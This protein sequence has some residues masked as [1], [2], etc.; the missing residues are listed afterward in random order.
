MRKLLTLAIISLLLISTFSIIQPQVKAETSTGLYAGGTNPGVVYEYKGGT[1]WASISSSLGWSITS[2]VNYKGKLFASVITHPDIYSSVGKVYRY[3]GAPDWTLVGT[4]DK[5]VTF[6]IIYKG[7]LYA[8]TATPAR[9]YKYIPAT[10]SWTKVLEYTPWFGFRSAY[11]WGDWL[12]LGEWYW[13]RFARWDGNTFQEFQPHY[14]GSCI[15]SIEEYKGALYAGAYIGRI[16]RVTAEPPVATAIWGPEPNYRYAWSLKTFKGYLYIGFDAN[17]TGIAPL[18]RYDGISFTQVWSYSTTTT[19]YHEGIISMATD[20]TYLYVGVGGQAVGY[21]PYMSG[22]GT[23]KV[24]RSSDGI[25]FEL[26]SETMGTGIQIL[27][28]PTIPDLILVSIEPIQVISNAKAL[29]ALKPTVI[30]INIK[31]TFSTRM[32]VDIFIFYDFRNRLYIERGPYGNGTPIDPGVNIVYIPGGPVYKE[33]HE[34]HPSWTTDPSWLEWSGS[35][36]DDKIEVWLDPLDKIPEIDEANNRMVRG[37]KIVFPRQLRILIIPVYFPDIGQGPFEPVLDFEREF[38][39]ATFPVSHK[40]TVPPTFEWVERHAIAWPGNP[41]YWDRSRGRWEWRIDWLY[42]NV[43]MPISRMAETAGWNRTVIVLQSLGDYDAWGLAPGMLGNPENR[44]PVIVTSRALEVLPGVV[45]HEIGHTFYLWHPHDIGPEIYDAYRYWVARRDFGRGP[46]PSMN[47]FM[48]YRSRVGLEVWI[49]KTRFDMDFANVAPGWY[50]AP[51]DPVAGVPPYRYRLEFA[52][53]RWNLMD[54]LTVN[55]HAVNAEPIILISGIMFRNGTIRL[56]PWYRLM[57]VPNIANGTVGNYSIVLISGGQIMAR[58]GFNASFCRLIE[59]DGILINVEWDKIPFILKIP[60]FPETTLIQIRDNA[61]N[62]LV[63]R[64]LTLNPPKV[65]IVYPNGGE[66]LGGLATHTI[67]W[68]AYDPDGDPLTY[69]I[70]YSEDN[71]ETWIPLA[72]DLNETNYLWDTSRLKTGTNYLI[73]VIATDGVN[74]GEDIS[75]NAFTI[76]AGYTH[77]IIDLD[78]DTLNL[79]SQGEWITIYIELPKGYNIRQIDIS[80]IK[81]NAT[82]SALT[83]PIG[84]G[85]YDADGVPDLMVKFDRN[86]VKRLFGVP[87]APKKYFIVIT[88]KV[89]NV[90]FVGTD[91]V[92]V[93]SPP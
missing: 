46:A 28:V 49:D 93:I 13:D 92:L 58:M 60:Y 68:E 88:G 33:S 71:G 10:T 52:T 2:L 66:I 17:G 44:I 27:Y 76:L 6:L 45:A 1:T 79:K 22:V 5:Q 4:L 72:I 65:N 89:S 26:I 24:Y 41:R 86:E 61:D 34:I 83:W 67:S 78:P 21:P 77:A 38:F 35:G 75:D 16:Y 7:E 84:I 85:D 54:Q 63:T 82:I 9:L 80:S 48:S 15:Y 70:A 31:S 8:G 57:G 14:W 91:F 74:T 42:E 32:W 87:P 73:K 62:I 18:Y 51:G 47:T 50:N 53:I 69:T 64:T 59:E 56:H 40:K 29:V 43:V 90:P 11:V 36:F 25:N 19:N 30:R 23:G 39:L 3:D 55:P 12:Y 20:G 81:L 37:M